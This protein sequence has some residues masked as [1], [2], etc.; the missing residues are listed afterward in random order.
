MTD[1]QDKPK[2]LFLD[3][4]ATGLVANFGHMLCCGFKW[5]HEKKPFIYSIETHPGRS[6]ISDEKLIAQ[7]A[8]LINNSHKDPKAAAKIRALANK[9][10]A[11]DS[12]LVIA[13]ANEID[14][15]D[16]VVTYYGAR[17]DI[18][19]IS[20][21][22]LRAQKGRF[23]ALRDSSHV[24]LWRTCRYKLKLNSNRLASVID[25][26]ELKNKK[27]PVA[28]PQW[29]A[30]GAGDRQALKYVV[31]HCIPDVLSLEE[32]YNTLLPLIAKHPRMSVE[33]LTC[34]NCGSPALQKR[35]YY[36]TASA[37]RRQRYKCTN[38]GKSS[39]GAGNGPERT[40]G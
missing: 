31:A 14:K 24:D 38:C 30:A 4:E 18:P 16:V 32:A 19:F 1:P 17:Y 11:D 21:R 6:V 33:K 9:G 8:Q 3:I 2:I 7:T 26:L 15:A 27:T 22:L 35:G 20:T 29:V 5:A 23:L 12:Q 28:G 10:Q 37:V 34:I 13:V 40:I 36:V 25:F 39:M